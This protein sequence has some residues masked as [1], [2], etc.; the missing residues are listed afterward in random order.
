MQQLSPRIGREK[1]RGTKSAVAGE[2]EVLNLWD[3]D[4]K[5]HLRSIA[6]TNLQV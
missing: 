2:Q 6:V 4:I 1:S 3:A 5:I